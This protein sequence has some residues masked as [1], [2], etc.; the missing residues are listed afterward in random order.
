MER[1]VEVKIEGQILEH[2]PTEN[3]S[4]IFFSD[5]YGFILPKERGLGIAKKVTKHTLFHLVF[6]FGTMSNSNFI[7][8]RGHH[9]QPT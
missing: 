1:I 4:E 6:R 5:S 2:E 8:T 9:H 3:G 7:I